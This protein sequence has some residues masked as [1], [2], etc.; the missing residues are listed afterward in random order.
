MVSLG[1]MLPPG[2]DVVKYIAGEPR[3]TKGIFSYS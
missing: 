2:V 3:L 1:G